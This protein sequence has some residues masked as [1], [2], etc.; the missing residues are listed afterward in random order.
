MSIGVGLD[1]GVTVPGSLN[2]A[3]VSGGGAPAATTSEVTPFSSE[4]APFGV[5]SFSLQAFEEDGSPST[6]AGGHPATLATS[7]YLNSK[8]PE[9]KISPA[10][11]VKDVVVDLPAGFVGDPQA[12]AKCPVNELLQQ[13]GVTDC[14]PASRVGTVVF[15]ASPGRAFR[16]SEGNNATTAVYNMQPESGFPAEFGFTYL[17]KAVYM[18]AS[19]VRVGGQLRL[20]VTVPGLPNL[21]TLGVTLLFFGDPGKHFGEPSGSVPFFTNPV[22]CAAGP[23]NATM[24]VDSWEGPANLRGNVYSAFA[25]SMTYPQVTGCDVLQFQPTLGVQPET[26]QADEP[27]GYTFTVA[28]PQNESPFTPGTPELK[29]ATVT[30]PAGVSLSPAAGDGLRGCAATGPEGINIG[31]GQILEAGQPGA[32]QDT[33][34]PEA[35]ELGAGHLGGDGSPYDDGLYHTAPGHCPAASTVGSVEIQTPLLTSPL[36]GH[37]FV[38]QPK[39]G[40]PGQPECTEADALNGNLFGV[41]LEAAGSGAIV[42]LAGAVSVNPSTGQITASFRENPQVPFSTLKLRFYGGPRAALANPQACGVAMTSG[43]FSPWSSPVTLDTQVFSPFTVDWDGAGGACPGS[44][45][46]TPSLLAETTNP[47]AGAFSPFSF[48]LSRGD[49][50]QY[51]SQLGVSTP[52]GLLGMISSVALCG[53]PQAAQG[54][55]SAGSE[56]GTATVAA[57][58]GSHPYWVTGHV[59]LTTGYKGAPFGLSVVVPAQAGPFNLGNVIVRSAINVDPVTS[60]VTITSDPLPQVIDGVPLRV[61]TI[62]V[63][64]SRPGFMFN[65]TNCQAKQVAVSVSGAQGALARV[66]S[67]FAAAGCSQLPFKPAFTVFTQ[68]NG[69]RHGASLDVKV[70]QKPG[71]AAIHK[72]NVQLPI[73]LPSRLTTLQKACTEAQFAANP[74]G[75]PEGSY[76]G[77]VKAVTPVLHSPLTGP[78]ILVSHGG[79][80]FPDLDVILQGEGVRIDLTGNT[81]I[82]KGITYSKF[83]T[84]PDAPISSFELYL[85]EGPHSILATTAPLCAL[86][87]TVTVRKSVIVHTHGHT[88]HTIKQVKQTTTT[89]LLM[90]TT[91]TG[92]NG[93]T[94]QQNTKITVTGC[95]KATA[96]KKATRVKTA[97][98]SGKAKAATVRVNS[99]TAYHAGAS[100]GSGR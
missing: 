57:G 88:H 48:T 13:S 18:F 5:E 53:E 23:L 10:G 50:Q 92:Q 94:T 44:L 28:N 25:E 87:K 22:D 58:A 37:V 75:C 73:A 49:R 67:P 24:E 71:E 59:Y 31:N 65:P 26:T 21:Q 70:T 95:A 79:E 62:N 30:L 97:S 14:P 98:R 1:G 3:S 78:A 72:V 19:T 86:T 82:K 8:E 80:A 76:V 2:S 47:A 6:Q 29:D 4:P 61:Q 15:E 27:S 83:E 20:R 45:P 16:A 51:L 93:T 11:E 38:A 55:C 40:G 96:A 36:M 52:P 60:A 63:S 41:Y 99:A 12:R 7:F 77:V 43:D 46:L 33:G 91:I 68:G 89:P 100:E 56:I 64:V 85:P 17:G 42:K 54:T 35:T 81:Q 9:H 32:G 69:N 66:S 39:C 90:P 74:A 84:V 34:D